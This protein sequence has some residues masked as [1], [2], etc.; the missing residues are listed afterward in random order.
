MTVQNSFSS[1]FE[2]TFLTLKIFNFEMSC[3]DVLLQT[4]PCAK[5]VITMLTVYILACLDFEMHCVNVPLQLFPSKGFVATIRA[6]EFCYSEMD[7]VFMV[8]YSSS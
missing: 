7:S 8:S 1:S 6:T 3:F 5:G 4:S 2:V